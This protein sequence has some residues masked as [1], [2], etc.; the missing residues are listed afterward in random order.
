[1]VKV[2]LGRPLRLIP[3]LWIILTVTFFMS[4]RVPG[5]PFSAESCYSVL[6]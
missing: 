6:F 4:K 2:I 3:V 1:M 5:G